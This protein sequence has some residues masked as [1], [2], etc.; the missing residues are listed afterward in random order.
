MAGQAPGERAHG[1]RGYS[2]DK[3]TP[4]VL[5]LLAEAWACAS[6]GGRY[7]WNR[8]AL[9]QASQDTSVTHLMGNDPTPL[10]P[11]A[12]APCPSSPGPWIAQPLHSIV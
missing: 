3:G 1:C 4:L 9:I 12:L 10:Q 5:G 11:P 8:T 6:Q 7:V 2:W